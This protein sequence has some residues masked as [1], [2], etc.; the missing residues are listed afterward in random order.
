MIYRTAP[1]SMTLNDPYPVSRSRHSLTLNI[2]ETVRDTE[3]Q[4]NTNMDLDTPYST[5]SFRMTLSDLEWL[6]KIFNDMKRRAVSLQQQSYLLP[7]SWESTSEYVHSVWYG[8]LERCGYPMVKTR[9]QCASPPRDN[10][11]PAGPLSDS[12]EIFCRWWIPKS[13]RSLISKLLTWV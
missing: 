12:D 10:A 2:S 11:I 3:F 8:K 4:W 7:Q 13:V 9:N 6:S 1:F 5:V